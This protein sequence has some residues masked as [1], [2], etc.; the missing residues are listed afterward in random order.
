MGL[1]LRLADADGRPRRPG[2]DV[3]LDV[4]PPRLDSAHRLAVVRAAGDRRERLHRPGSDAEPGSP[5][6]WLECADRSVEAILDALRDGRVAISA[7]PDG[8]VLIRDGDE[9]VPVDA[10]GHELVTAGESAWLVAD[11]L[12]AA[13]SP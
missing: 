3:A 9:S 10:D 6:T 11:G 1:G 13:Y 8:P 5:T 4:G 7:S 2:R 12:V